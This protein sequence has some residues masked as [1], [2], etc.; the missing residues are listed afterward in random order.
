MTDIVEVY[1]CQNEAE[2]VILINTLLEHGIHARV[3]GEHLQ[4][5]IGELPPGRD[6]ALQLWTNLADQAAARAILQEYEDGRKETSAQVPGPGWTC[7]RC[8]TNVEPPF[9][10]CWNCLYDPS[11][12]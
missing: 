4:A 6:T 9:Q 10:V 8:H 7:P 3:V 11:A 12:C 5:A 2:A 1:R